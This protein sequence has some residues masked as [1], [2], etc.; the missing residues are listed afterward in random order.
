[1]ATAA[2]DGSASASASAADDSKLLEAAIKETMTP[3]SSDGAGSSDKGVHV[4]SY[5]LLDT[6]DNIRCTIPHIGHCSFVA[7]QTHTVVT[8]DWCVTPSSGAKLFVRTGEGKHELGFKSVVE[9][10]LTSHGCKQVQQNDAV[11]LQPCVSPNLTPPRSPATLARLA[12]QQRR[13][14][15]GCV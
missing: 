10:Y 5:E 9:P 15:H 3:S 4:Q 1:M 11:P 2:G 8:T 6:K 7:Q 13:L 14:C 12:L